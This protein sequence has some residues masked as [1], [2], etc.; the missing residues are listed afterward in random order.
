MEETIEIPAKCTNCGDGSH[1]YSDTD[2]T[3]ARVIYHMPKYLERLMTDV[4]WLSGRYCRGCDKQ[5]LVKTWGPNKQSKELN[6]YMSEIRTLR[7]TLSKK[8]FDMIF[9]GEKKEEYREIKDHWDKRLLSKDEGQQFKEYDV[10]QFF[11]GAY[12]SED[13]PN[14]KIEFNGTKIGAGKTEWGASKGVIYY[15]ISLGSLIK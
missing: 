14:F 13:L 6:N 10:V 15:V 7:M 12:L 4:Q 1:T 2:K 11:N 3:L 8:W 9:A 5:L